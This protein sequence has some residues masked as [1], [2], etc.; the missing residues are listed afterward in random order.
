MALTPLGSNARE[1]RETLRCW[2]GKKS[3]EEVLPLYLNEGGTWP[4]EL[5]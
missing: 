4:R 3:R 5:T 1:L 2:N